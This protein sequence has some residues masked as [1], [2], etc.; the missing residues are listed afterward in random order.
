MFGYI[1]DSHLIIR[2]K[3]TRELKDAIAVAFRLTAIRCISRVQLFD[4]I[5]FIVKDENNQD[6]IIIEHHG[7]LENIGDFEYGNI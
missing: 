2:T 3:T 1:K 4:T 7:K 5:L 6:L